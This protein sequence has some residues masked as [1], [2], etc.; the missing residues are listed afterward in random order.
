MIFRRTPGPVQTTGEDDRGG[1]VCEGELLNAS[2]GDTDRIGNL[3][4]NGPD[5]DNCPCI[6]GWLEEE[7]KL[8]RF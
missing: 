4:V 1:L 6:D 5:G 8:D 2:V 7:G 3:D